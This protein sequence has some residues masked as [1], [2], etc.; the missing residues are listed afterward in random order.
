MTDSDTK[1]TGQVQIFIVALGFVTGFLLWIYT[2]YLYQPASITEPIVVWSVLL[3]GSTLMGM[4]VGSLTNRAFWLLAVA[5]IL[6]IGLSG[7]YTGYQ[8]SPDPLVSRADT[9]YFYYL[10]PQVIAWF[11]LLFYAR[12]WL[13][14]RNLSFPYSDLFDASWDH[15]LVIGL[16]ALLVGL[17]WGLLGLWS[18]LFNM[19][20]IDFFE[21][22]FIDDPFAFMATGLV[23]GVGVT[24]FRRQINAVEVLRRILRALMRWLL[25]LLVLMILI[26]LATLPFTGL[27]A[28]WETRYA[29][30]LLLLIVAVFLFLFNAVFQDTGEGGYPAWLAVVIKFSM[31][32]MPVFVAL[33]VY[34]IG[35]RVTQYG[36]TLD[37]L[38]AA[39]VAAIAA[40][41]AVSYSYALIRRRTNWFDMV[42][43]TNRV[44]AA[45]IAV[46]CILACTPLLNLKKISADSQ[47]ALLNNGKISTARFDL[48]YLRFN[49]GRPGHEALLALKDSEHARDNPK[50]LTA[51]ESILEEYSRYG[52]MPI[53]DKIETTKDVREYI[54]VQPVSTQVPEA[55]W[56][57]ILDDREK[58]SR[59]FNSDIKCYLFAVDVFGDERN[60]FILLSNFKYVQNERV[61]GLKG[62]HWEYIGTASLPFVEQVGT[63][64][65]LNAIKRGDYQVGPSK[66]RSLTIGKRKFQFREYD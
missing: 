36:W 40:G 45:V 11:I 56:Q 34:A 21:R 9:L 57:L 19:I 12:T 50:F 42:I 54:G 47:V 39:I 63:N 4:L 13:Q 30:L 1:L 61:Y 20:G 62:D 65:L 14:H 16:T 66:W 37:R 52:V 29:S 22:L 5:Y 3:G 51:I 55:V 32:T 60:E 48:N 64:E 35:L 17:F 46:V 43:E 26:F 7:L 49:L 6:I 58:D 38:W 53:R 23:I 2:S 59:C 10:W 25:P 27:Q 8:L 41:F 18:G 24:V 44:M 33:A 28:L 31:L 15:F